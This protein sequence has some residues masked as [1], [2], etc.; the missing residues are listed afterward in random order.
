MR[1]QWAAILAVVIMLGGPAVVLLAADL[2]GPKFTCYK[3]TPWSDISSAEALYLFT[4]GGDKNLTP[5]GTIYISKGRWQD[6]N[7]GIKRHFTPCK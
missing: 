4:N 1:K 6:F 7:P 5:G 2:F 3:F